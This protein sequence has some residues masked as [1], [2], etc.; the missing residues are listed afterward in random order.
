MGD[1]TEED[2]TDSDD[3]EDEEHPLPCV[4]KSH[5]KPMILMSLGRSGTSSMYSVLSKLSGGKELPFL[6]LTGSST[7]R[8]R[9]FFREIIPKDDVYGDWIL[10]FIC[11][12]QK[13]HPDEGLVG[14]K[15]RV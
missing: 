8:S 2:H 5:P 9:T 14:F 10:Q 4:L 1:N 3:A 12:E 13:T 15:V 7:D 11:H 6:E